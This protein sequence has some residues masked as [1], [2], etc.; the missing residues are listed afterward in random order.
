MRTGVWATQKHNERVL[1]Q[2]YRTSKDVFLIFKV[3]KGHAF[4]GYARYPHSH[5]SGNSITYDRA[6]WKDGLAMKG[7]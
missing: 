5:L 7:L 3:R 2:A 1:D 4:C 6:G